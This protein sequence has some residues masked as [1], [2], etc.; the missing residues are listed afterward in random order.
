MALHEALRVELDSNQ[1][2]LHCQ[3]RFFP[4][5][6]NQSGKRYPDLCIIDSRYYFLAPLNV[7][8]KGF[9]IHGPSIQIEI[10]LRRLNYRDEQ[11][12]DW[13]EDLIKLASWRDSWYGHNPP[14]S[15]S[16]G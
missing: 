8:S 10:K 12:A 16:D 13:I 11:L 2:G 5:P 3:P 9:Q 4:S 1:I 7:S 14:E 6:G 15:Y